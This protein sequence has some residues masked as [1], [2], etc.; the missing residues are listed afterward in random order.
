MEKSFKS[1][2][3]IISNL[4]DEDLTVS[5]C[6]SERST[7]GDVHT[8]AKFEGCEND[9]QRY[10]TTQITVHISNHTGEIYCE[11][12]I[13]IF[14][15]IPVSLIDWIE[16][17]DRENRGHNIGRTLHEEA[18]RYIEKEKNIDR[19]YTKIE[20]SRMRSV[21]IETG[22]KQVENGSNEVWCRKEL[23]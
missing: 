17:V 10:K 5:I 14:D 8:V 3:R 13:H 9:G 7:K 23:N 19:I 16:V 20:N 4:V 22:F 15:N 12:I 2:L 21:N 18:V 11:V 6:E 1:S